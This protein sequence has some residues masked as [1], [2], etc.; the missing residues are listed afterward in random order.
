MLTRTGHR[1]VNLY[2]LASRPLAY[3]ALLGERGHTA[4][5]HVDVPIGGPVPVAVRDAQVGGVVVPRPAAH[6]PEAIIDLS[7]RGLEACHKWRTFSITN[8]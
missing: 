6:H 2:H 8:A 4:A 1:S 7:P 5:P 3:R